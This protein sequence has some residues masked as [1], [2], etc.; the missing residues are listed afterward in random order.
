MRQEFPAWVDQ[1]TRKHLISG[2][3]HA[4]LINLI[5][6]AMKSPPYRFQLRDGLRTLGEQ[7]LYFRTGKSKTMKSR[8]LAGGPQKVS[9]A[10]DFVVYDCKG[11][12]SWEVRFYKAVAEHIK[13][14]ALQENIAIVWGGDWKTFGDNPHIELDRKVY[15]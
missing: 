5:Y 11:K 15:P 6:L 9:R 13:K 10:V 14:I 7:E 1:N 8:H 4:D 12:L 2:E 3:V